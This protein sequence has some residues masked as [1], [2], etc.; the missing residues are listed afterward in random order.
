MSWGASLTLALCCV[1]PGD[2]QSAQIAPQSPLQRDYAGPTS[3]RPAEDGLAAPQRAQEVEPHVDPPPPAARSRA[4]G[5]LP[6]TTFID[7]S[8][9]PPRAHALARGLEQP[10]ILTVM[11]GPLPDEEAILFA[12]RRAVTFHPGAQVRTRMGAVSPFR[13]DADGGR[14]GE[15]AYV[16]G[17]VRWNPV[18]GL[19]HRERIKFVGM[20]DVANGRW[21]PTRFEPP[22]NDLV[23]DGT[24]PIPTGLRTVDPR[25]LYLQWTSSYGQLRVGQMA[26]GWGEGLVSNDGN[27]MDRFGDLKFGNDGDGT[28]VERIMFATKPLS[29]VHTTAR[30]LVVGFSADLVFRDPNASLV[31][32]D[33]AGQGI[34]FARW[35]PRRSPGASLGGY[36]AYRG[37]R[38]ADDGDD[39]ENDDQ[40][41]VLVADFAGQGYR[42]LRPGLALLGGFE[43]AV[44]RGRT[45]VL[46]G[47]RDWHTVMQAGAA[48]R[49]YVGDPARWLAGL[50]AGWFSGDGDPDDGQLN[51]FQAAPGYTAG[52]LLFPF[53]Q[54]WQSARSAS[55]ARD[56]ALSGVPPNGVEQ[57][58]T[59]GR[60]GNVAFVHPKA[61]YGF[62]ERFE[63][64]GGPLFALSSAP[65]S[66][67]YAT[68][69]GGGAPTNALGGEVQSRRL[70]TELDLGLRA[71]Y[72]FRELWFQAG[73]QGGVLFPGPAFA[74][75]QGS[76]DG[77]L[78]GGWFRA[79]L[80]Y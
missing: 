64:W 65:L 28:I 30:D 70:G 45:T 79:E 63:L 15:G 43:A 3:V 5:T 38:I 54:G 75:A 44:I 34:I 51:T 17:R 68:L 55:L 25:E 29:N 58:P 67:P 69:I 47:E 72:G 60:V 10:R 26:F 12:R 48:A 33:L 73:V 32:G 7:V 49:G 57:V 18:L 22:V 35:E 9:Y 11:R 6:P 71:R 52:L 62:L 2:R 19:G 74:D 42:Y 66:D 16:A 14:Y 36:I 24:T 80:R 76:R 46:R 23:R 1:A 31:E 37:Q 8:A 53:V 20:V 13:I 27:N 78:Y 77:P 40:L 59:D 50:D 41:Q 21:A 56:P 61:R 4:D 39:I